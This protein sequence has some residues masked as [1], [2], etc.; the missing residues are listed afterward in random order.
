MALHVPKA[1]GFAQMLKD[2]AMVSV[3]QKLLVT[4]L[5]ITPFVCRRVFVIASVRSRG[6]GV[7]Q[8][9]RLQGVCGHREDRVR[10]ERHEQNSHQP[11]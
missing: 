2:G 10:S 8:H 3:L 9:C 6:S 4:R 7:P 11:H 1:P 5:R